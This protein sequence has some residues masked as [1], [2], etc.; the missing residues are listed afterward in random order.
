VRLQHDA[1]HDTL[2]VPL[3]SGSS[4]LAALAATEAIAI[5]PAEVQSVAAGERIELLRCD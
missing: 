1:D 3:A 4:S 5:I 2:A